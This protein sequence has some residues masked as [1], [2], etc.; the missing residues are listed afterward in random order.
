MQ[1][2]TRTSESCKRAKQEELYADPCLFDLE[3]V[4]EAAAAGYLSGTGIQD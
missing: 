4:K 1:P 2:S 3:A